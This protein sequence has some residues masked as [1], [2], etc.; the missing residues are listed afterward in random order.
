MEPVNIIVL[1]EKQTISLNFADPLALDIEFNRTSEVFDEI[2]PGNLA[3]KIAGNEL[4]GI[5]SISNLGNIVNA[6]TGFISLIL[7]VDGIEAEN[8]LNLQAKEQNITSEEGLQKL[9]MQ[10]KVDIIIKDMSAVGGSSI[11]LPVFF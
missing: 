8:L 11:Q 5:V 2:S 7:H 10:G 6:D 1:G 9:S 3:I 4:P